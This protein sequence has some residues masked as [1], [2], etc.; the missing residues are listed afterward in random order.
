MDIKQLRY[1]TAIV[2]EGQ[3]TRAAKK[4]HMAQPPLS[5]QLKLMEQEL[6]VPLIERKGKRLELTKPGKVLYDRTIPLLQ[7][8]E[9]VLTEVKE[10]HD[11]L[12]GALTFGAV[13]SC[14]ANLLEPIRL[15]KKQHPAVSFQ[16]REGDSFLLGEYL[17]NREIEFAVIRLPIDMNHFSSIHLQSEPFVAVIPESWIS[18]KLNKSS[19]PLNELQSMPLLLLHRLSGVGQFEMI[20]EEFKKQGVDPIIA[21][22]CPDVNI[23]LSLAS[24]GIGAA[25]VPQST[26]RSLKISNVKM[27]E[28]TDFHVK[29]E[30]AVIWLKDRY[31]SR[32]AEEMIKQIK[33]SAGVI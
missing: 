15:Y 20:V 18:N 29:A 13:K 8:L 3:I 9:D 28:I 21:C 24:I 6:G 5:Q 31:L 17:K 33:S 1:F 25:I 19:I 30:S 23:L 2:Q 27:M 10:T 7:S 22:E 12:R 32:S 14:F 16:I 4:L 26:L 11:G